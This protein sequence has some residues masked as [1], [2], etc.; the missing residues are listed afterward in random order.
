MKPTAGIVLFSLLFLGA[1]AQEPEPQT[2]APQQE[3]TAHQESAENEGSSAATRGSEDTNLSDPQVAAGE[4]VY[5]ANCAGCHDSGTGGAPRP[6]KKE[7]WVPLIA[8]GMDVMIKRSVEG[9]VGKNGTMPPKGGNAE[10]TET[11]VSNA[12]KYMVFKSR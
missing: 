10:L 4:E 6:G 9:F 1:C 11:E 12:V 8:Q 5:E 7:E 3:T 2:E